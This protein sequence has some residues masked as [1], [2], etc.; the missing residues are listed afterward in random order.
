MNALGLRRQ[1]DVV[2]PQRGEQRLRGH[3]CSVIGKLISGLGL[4]GVREPGLG[5]G[6]VDALARRRVAEVAL[7]LVL[8]ERAVGEDRQLELGLAADTEVAEALVRGVDDRLHRVVDGFR[9]QRLDRAR[10]LDLLDRDRRAGLAVALGGTRG[11]VRRDDAAIARGEHAEREHVERDAVLAAVG[12]PRLRGQLHDQLDAHVRHG[13]APHLRG[14]LVGEGARVV[15]ERARDELLALEVRRAGAN[16]VPC[17]AVDLDARA[18]NARRQR[19]RDRLLLRV[20]RPDIERVAIGVDEH[21]RARELGR[22]CIA[23]VTALPLLR[24]VAGVAGRGQRPHEIFDAMDLLRV[25]RL[26]LERVV[27]VQA[28]CAHEHHQDRERRPHRESFWVRYDLS[29]SSASTGSATTIGTV[30]FISSSS[31]T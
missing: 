20:P 21:R 24:V 13:L 19:D 10:I 9:R 17:L 11:R 6:L 12:P 31:S 2:G 29:R 5:H 3:C 4:L 22:A 27:G 1:R 15:V 30:F 23:D 26:G 16:D 25:R 14:R 28:R 7:L 18:A 8:A